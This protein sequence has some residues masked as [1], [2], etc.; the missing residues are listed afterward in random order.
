M[1]VAAINPSL[2]RLVL[3]VLF[4]VFFQLLRAAKMSRGSNP[5]PGRN[6]GKG[7]QLGEAL[8]E[9]MRQA[10][11]RERQSR[12]PADQDQ[13]QSREEFRLPPFQQPP[14]IKPESSFIPSLLLLALLGCLVLM[15]YRYWAG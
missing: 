1:H 11:E 6:A 8:R 14:A 5:V 15:A 9:A 10:A 2:I 13:T 3:V 12:S 7:S 4:V